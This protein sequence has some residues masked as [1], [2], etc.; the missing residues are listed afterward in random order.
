MDIK[1]Y[2]IVCDELSFQ[3]SHLKFSISIYDVAS[4]MT[5]QLNKVNTDNENKNYGNFVIILDQ[6]HKDTPI[7]YPENYYCH[8]FDEL[9]TMITFIAEHQDLYIDSLDEFDSASYI[10]E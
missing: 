9:K 7:N 3:L 2:K 5:Y 6:Q 1:Q 10:T 4:Q 8:T